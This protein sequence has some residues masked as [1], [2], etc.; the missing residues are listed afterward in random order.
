MLFDGKLQLVGESRIR[1]ERRVHNGFG[2][3]RDFDVALQRQRVGFVYKPS[4][5]FEIKV[6][7]QD[8]RAPLYGTGAPNSMRDGADLYEAYIDLFPKKKTGFAARF[9]RSVLS[10]GDTRLIGSPQ[11][12]NLT[13]SYDVGRLEWRTAK[14]TFQMIYAS[15]VQIRI[16][17]F[18]RPTWNEHIWGTYN[19]FGKWAELYVLR[20]NQ[21][22]LLESVVTGGRL[23]KN[24]P[25]KWKLTLEPVLQRVK[26]TAAVPS[27]EGAQVVTFARKIG[28]V[29]NA[30]EYKYASSGFD[31]IYPAAHD[32][33]GHEDLF[34]WRNLHNFRY[35]GTWRPNKNL[36]WSFM[37]NANW[38]ADPRVGVFNIPN[39]LIVRDPTGRAGRWAGHEA[40][41]F[42]NW[43]YRKF[44]TLGGGFG[45][46]VNGA[47]FRAT[48][49]NRSPAF[50]YIT[51]VFSM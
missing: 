44:L 48:T 28:N 30:L 26:R 21:P 31:Q 24:L 47:Y 43:Q 13:R 8:T 19:F 4:N 29:D 10:Y 25:G 9:G 17:R 37:Y 15:P 3:S 35:F 33:L 6:V 49:P 36:A 50:V 34:G 42:I 18:N 5:T 2:A 14:N 46:F 23:M 39:R 51:H 27:T 41:S 7:G 22:G 11:W 40:D 12:A 45:V 32:K 20:H 16:Y 38:V 1:F